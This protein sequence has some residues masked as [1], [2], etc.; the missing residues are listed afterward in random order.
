MGTTSDRERIEDLIA[1]CRVDRPEHFRLADRDPGATNGVKDKTAAKERL[2][3]GVE[4]LFELQAKLAAQETHG[5][6][7]ALQ[8]LDAAGKD[9]VIKHVMTGLNPQGVTVHSFKTPSTEELAHHFLWRTTL[10]LPRRG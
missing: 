5:V 4:R 6:V 1:P 7:V 3:E 9:G 10:A 8:A 2:D